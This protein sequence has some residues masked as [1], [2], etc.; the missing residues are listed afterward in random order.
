MSVIDFTKNI[1]AGYTF[2]G[3][4][5]YMG[6]AM[7][8][9]KVIKPIKI[10]I[11]LATLN[12]HGL[13]A[14]ATGTGKTKT[15]QVLTES[16][17]RNGVPT[18]VMDI[19]GDLSGISQEGEP[20][21]KIN[22]RIAELGIEWKPEKLPS[23][24][25]TLGSQGVKMR[26]TLT[27]FGSVLLGK[28]MN[29]TD[30]QNAVLGMVFKYC[31][32]RNIPLLDFNDL[33]KVLQYY[34]TEG[35][36]KEIEAEYGSVATSSIGAITRNII[37]LEEQGVNEIFG[38]PSFDVFDLVKTDSTGKGYINIVR[39]M[40]L[41]SKPQLFATFML[42]LVNKIYSKFPEVGDAEKPKLCLFIDEAHLI[43]ENADNVLL[44]QITTTIKLIRS[45]G[46]GIFFITQNP[47]DIP[48][49]VLSQLG[50]KLQHSL[51][52]F[53]AIDRKAIKVASENYPV[54]EYYQ[55]ENLLTELGIGE[56]LITCLSEK[57][58]PTPLAHIM[59]TPPT[60]RMDV[61]SDL[62][63][64]SILNSSMMYQKYK[65]AINRE[66]AEEILQS[67]MDQL[68]AEKLKVE[69]ELK[70]AKEAEKLAKETGKTTGKDDK[71]VVDQL[72]NNHYTKIIGGVVL[73]EISKAVMK[74]LGF[75]KK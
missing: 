9:K 6:T 2:K 33:K 56:A 49:S 29:L 8:D 62:E 54:S 59:V 4:S 38:E 67:K 30:V 43:F 5:F 14:G 36:K 31:S 18:L 24:F 3:P 51:R 13:I 53:T 45:K 42:S 19:K 55:T 64:Q 7:L 16:L 61:V 34:G 72:A 37:Q 70:A 71:T 50:L 44:Q 60:T 48:Q 46:V 52:A 75:G 22:A 58:T 12:R 39:L 69:E 63:V 73:R 10:N 20:N 25:L 28:L 15:L 26:T 65:D 32:D 40:D 35:G 66:S 1:D 74:A 57:G 41:Q 27:E 11:P 17:S 47:S 23:E 68:N 21:E